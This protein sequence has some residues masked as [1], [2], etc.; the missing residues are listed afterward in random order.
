MYTIDPI[1]ITLLFH[2]LVLFNISNMSD[3]MGAYRV[4]PARSG[5]SK[6]KGKCKEFIEQGA[7]R[8]GSLGDFD[9]RPMYYWRCKLY[10]QKNPYV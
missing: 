2:I 9:G 1:N 5:R 10:A 8:F 3:Y 7:L 6:C 4:E